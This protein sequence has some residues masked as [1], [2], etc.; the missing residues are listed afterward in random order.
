MILQKFDKLPLRDSLMFIGGELVASES[1]QWMESRQRRAK[2]RWEV[3]FPPPF[4]LTPING[5]SA[6]TNLL[7]TGKQILTY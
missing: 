4:C 6:L 3:I 2:R 1:G 5:I 7:S